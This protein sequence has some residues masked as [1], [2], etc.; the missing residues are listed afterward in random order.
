VKLKNAF[1]L[2]LGAVLAGCSDSPTEPTV[3]VSGSTSFSY[4]GAGAASATSYS[5]SGA[6][7]ANLEST[8]GSSSWAAGGV[9]ASLGETAIMAS[10]P[11]ASNRWDITIISIARTAVGTSN[12]VSSCTANV[13][14][15]V[16][17][18]FNVSQDLFTSFNYFCTLTTGSVT[19]SAISST[20]V[21]GTF[22]GSGTCSNPSDVETP[23]T[24]TNGSFNVGITPDIGF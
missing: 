20:N 13:C 24:V 11:R 14:T 15:S 21:T 22:S 12:I 5:A 4:T 9:D 23:F 8:W 16:S 1:V 7:P 2:A 6:V 17:V 19:I 3:G 18:I 10:V